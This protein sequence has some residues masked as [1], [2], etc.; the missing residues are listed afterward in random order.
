MREIKSNLAALSAQMVVMMEEV[1]K[2]G[3]GSAKG[4]KQVSFQENKEAS[5]R[6]SINS[7]MVM[8]MPPYFVNGLFNVFRQDIGCIA[9]S[10][11]ICCPL[12]APH[13][14][15]LVHSSNGGDD[16]GG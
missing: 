4:E 12:A 9:S 11:L 16:G 10:F 7:L 14:L 6:A 2:R 3:K 8:L 1:K 5:R 15:L 13:Y